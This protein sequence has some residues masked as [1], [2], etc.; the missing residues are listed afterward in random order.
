MFKQITFDANIYKEHV[1]CVLSATKSSLTLALIL[2]SLEPN[3]LNRVSVCV[4]ADIVPELA[5]SLC[6]LQHIATFPSK[7]NN[8]CLTSQLFRD[9]SANV[10]FIY[11]EAAILSAAIQEILCN[12]SVKQENSVIFQ[13]P[14][15]IL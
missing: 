6:S 11:L 5:A 13:T 8:T 15:F 2:V 14:A 3:D 9:I 10:S 1:L 7:K 12:A 4:I